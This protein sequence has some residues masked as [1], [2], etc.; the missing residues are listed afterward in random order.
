MTGQGQEA[1]AWRRLT[2]PAGVTWLGLGINC[3]FSA[4]KIVAGLLFSSQAILADGLH[5]ISDMATDVAVLAGL[6]VS[7]KPAD[8]AHNY[9][10]RRATTLVTLFVGAA[11]LLAAGWIGYTAVVTMREEHSAVEGLIPFIIAAA[12]VPVKELLYQVTRRV[13]IRVSDSSLVANAWHHRSDAWASATAAL[14][15]AVVTFGGPRWAFVDHVTALVLVAFL[16]VM[17]AKIIWTS[18]SDLM[19]RA[20][21][22]VTLASIRRAVAQ[23]AGVRSFHGIRARRVGDMVEMDVHVQ[24]DPQLTVS[25]GHDIARSVRQ[26]VVQ[27]NPQVSQV[28][29]HV[30]PSP[31]RPEEQT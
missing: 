25:Q 5:S 18:G 1:S 7:S 24:V 9:G 15:L 20:P 4:A 6:R 19:D 22:D 21:D 27:Q 30:E 28:I 10:H 31:E 26:R 17:A 3:F 14:G 29:V 13:G 23:T 16:I 8:E 12:S 11:L 2:T